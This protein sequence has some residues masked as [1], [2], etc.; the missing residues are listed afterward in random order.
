MNTIPTLEEA[1]G[2]ILNDNGA[3]ETDVINAIE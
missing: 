2:K 1:W 3:M